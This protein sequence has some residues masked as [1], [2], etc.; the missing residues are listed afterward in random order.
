MVPSLLS[1]LSFG[2]IFR[3]QLFQKLASMSRDFR[4][5]DYFFMAMYYAN[6]YPTE[7][8]MMSVFYRN[9]KTIRH[10]CWY[11]LKKIAALKS[12]K[13]VWP[14]EW[15]DEDTELDLPVFLCTVDG[16]HCRILEPYHPLYCK[17]TSYYSHKSKK[18]GLNYEVA[19]SVFENRVVWI[20][21]PFPANKHDLTIF[22]EQLKKKIP[23]SRRAIG[24]RAYADPRVTTPNPQ[25]SR[26]LQKF[27][28]RARSRQETFN[29]RL[30][31]F[32]CLKEVF[33]HSHNKHKICFEAICVICQYQMENGSPLFDV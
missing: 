14:E 5:V 6:C 26:A 10:W 3:Q 33:R 1:C 4:D 30:K 13:I 27:L 32:N 19:I 28:S 8:R 29:D 15:S 25:H 12:Q 11:Y 17:D 22:Q 16:T 23:P 31:N 20:N 21:G 7:E 9:E 2:K 18:A 24:D